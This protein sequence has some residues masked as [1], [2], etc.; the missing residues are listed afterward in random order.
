MTL[1][2]FAEKYHLKIKRDGCDDPGVYGRVKGAKR[3]EDN[4][5]VYTDG[6]KFYVYFNF[7]TV[8]RWNSAR[9]RLLAAGAHAAMT[10]AYDGV[11]LFDP[12]D[13]PLVRLV[14]KLAHIRVKRQL[15]DEQKAEIRQRF[16]KS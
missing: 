12:A 11:L 7:P 14:L 3:L 6:D 13:E 2:E 8:G 15:T 1:L 10:C 9:K 5:H 16:K 4:H